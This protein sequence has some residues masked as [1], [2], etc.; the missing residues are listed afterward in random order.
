M[1]SRVLVDETGSL[2]SRTWQALRVRADGQDLGLVREE[3]NEAVFRDPLFPNL[4]GT[5]RDLLRLGYRVYM[6]DHN[7]DPIRHTH[8]ILST[9]KE[10]AKDIMYKVKSATHRC[11]MNH[12]KSE[13]TLDNQT[14][15][16][17]CNLPS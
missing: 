13:D 2:T 1:P 8:A 17:F 9:G 11:L 5:T 16:C 12:L 10:S 3:T 6:L 14:R 7:F 15:L 4:V